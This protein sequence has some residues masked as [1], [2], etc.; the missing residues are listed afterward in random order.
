MSK[1]LTRLTFCAVRNVYHKTTCVN[2]ITEVVK[3]SNFN[4]GKYNVLSSVI[5]TF[6]VNNSLREAIQPTAALDNATI[7]L[8]KKAIYK[9]VAL[10]DLPQK[11]GQFLAIAYATANSY[12]LPKIKEALQ[13]QKL[14]EPGT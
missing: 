12:D 4:C 3:F 1:F 8:K 5:R 14:Y 10:E 9:K 7:P 2:T 6:S 13:K 11:E